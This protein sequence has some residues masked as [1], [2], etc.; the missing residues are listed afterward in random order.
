MTLPKLTKISTDGYPFYRFEH[1]GDTYEVNRFATGRG[2]WNI[3][4]TRDGKRIDSHTGFD[5]RRAAIES[6]IETPQAETGQTATDQFQPGE[7]RVVG[8]GTTQILLA[9]RDNGQEIVC[10]SSLYSDHGRRMVHAPRC[11]GDP[12]PWVPMF[13]QFDSRAH[14]YAS[15]DCVARP[16]RTSA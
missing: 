10:N 3:E 8:N 4:C 14:R 6:V 11:A 5:T 7:R 13:D 12:Q 15:S 9:A 16:L 2:A 1:N